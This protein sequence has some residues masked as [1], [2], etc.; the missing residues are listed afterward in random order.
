MD[1]N[2]VVKPDIAAPTK[3]YTAAGTQP[4]AAIDLG[5]LKGTKFTRLYKYLLHWKRCF[6]QSFCALSLL[7][8]THAFLENDLFIDMCVHFQVFRGAAQKRSLK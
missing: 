8:H 7:L 2:Q 3:K 6:N 5:S 4:T 1:R